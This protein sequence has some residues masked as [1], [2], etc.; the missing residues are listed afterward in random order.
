MKSNIVRL[1]FAVF[2]FIFTGASDSLAVSN[3]G[4]VS[5][6]T[7]TLPRPIPQDQ[8]VIPHQAGQISSVGSLYTWQ[9]KNLD[10]QFLSAELVIKDKN[11]QAWTVTSKKSRSFD[12]TF[13]GYVPAGSPFFLPES[14]STDD[15]LK[16]VWKRTAKGL[17]RISSAKPMAV[18]SAKQESGK[19]IVYGVWY[20]YKDPTARLVNGKIK[21]SNEF[22]TVEQ[23]HAYAARMASFT[24]PLPEIVVK[25]PELYVVDYHTPN[26]GD[27]VVMKPFEVRSD[28]L[29]GEWEFHYATKR[30]SPASDGSV[31]VTRKSDYVIITQVDPTSPAG[32]AGFKSGMYVWSL[33]GVSTVGLSSSD[34][35]KRLVGKV[36]VG[37]TKIEVSDSLKGT[38]YFIAVPMEKLEGQ[39]SSTIASLP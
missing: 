22:D 6:V 11:V 32:K 16:E 21:Q 20:S 33:N 14:M 37:D 1:F 7:I 28:K 25:N 23:F 13:F 36:S 2:A 3:S 30:S 4:D 39:K 19:T 12:P 24:M 29:W 9:R 27:V 26:Q 34:E 18:N 15:V 38:H 8:V 31:Q 35:F 10:Q 5:E 17:E